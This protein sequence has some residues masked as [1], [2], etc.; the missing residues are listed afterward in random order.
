MKLINVREVFNDIDMMEYE[1]INQIVS[2]YFLFWGSE[3]AIPHSLYIGNKHLDKIHK[4]F[5][6][7]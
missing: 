7:K 3:L 6:L 1:T 4:L 2:R 5:G